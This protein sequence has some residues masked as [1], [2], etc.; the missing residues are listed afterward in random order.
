MDAKLANLFVYAG[1]WILMG[2]ATALAVA[3]GA[4]A[5]PPFRE[6]EVLFAAKQ[7]I[8]SAFGFLATGL[9][10]WLSAN[11]PQLGTEETVKKASSKKTGI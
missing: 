3:I 10:V 6:G 11:R 5:V 8:G 2:I 4:G 1:L 9:G 7:E